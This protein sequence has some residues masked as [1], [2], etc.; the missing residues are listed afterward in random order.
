MT[1]QE[2]TI[3]PE[4]RDLLP[5]LTPEEREQLR[6]NLIAD[7]R[8][9]DPLVVW[10]RQGERV[11]VDGHNRYELCQEL[12]LQYTYTVRTWATKA[13]VIAWMLNHQFGRRSLTPKRMAYIRGKLYLETKK[14]PVDNLVPGAA[15]QEK[16]KNPINSSSAQ[17]ANSKKASEVV[18]ETA[19]VH[20]STVRRDAA[21][22]ESLDSLSG[23]VRSAILDGRVK[24]T[25]AD[26]DWLV[27]LNDRGEQRRIVDAILA[28]EYRTLGEAME[29]AANASTGGEAASEA[30]DEAQEAEPYTGPVDGWGV[31]IQP[32][33]REAFDPARL[34]QFD[35]M[36]S[37]LKKA[38]KLWS[39][40]AETP[41]GAYMLRPGLSVNT[42]E[43]Y[44]SRAIKDAI[45]AVEDVRPTY[46]V[47]PRA[48]HA[49]AH[50]ESVPYGGDKHDENCTLCHGL[51]WSRALGREEIDPAV[52]AKIKEAFGV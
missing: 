20:A 51:N 45:A 49:L 44:R 5:P 30:T 21:L 31:P 29:A 34:A 19:G 1:K 26:V 8:A 28:G 35:E 40:L 43:R 41:S 4:L 3:D 36:L 13:D 38:D 37:H 46:T 16:S 39:V 25:K 48:Y 15:H 10:Q 52:T 18:A 2:L 50:P 32:H 33:A 12:G 6:E 27:G 17:I 23:F 9:L 7:G 42:R 24:T 11:I 47:C 14:N 22:A